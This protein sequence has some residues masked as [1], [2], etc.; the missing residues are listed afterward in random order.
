MLQSP[1]YFLWEGLFLSRTQDVFQANRM[2][3]VYEKAQRHKRLLLP[4]N[5]NFSKS[6]TTLRSQ[7]HVCRLSCVLDGS[8]TYSTNRLQTVVSWWCHTENPRPSL[9]GVYQQCVLTAQVNVLLISVGVSRNVYLEASKMGWWDREEKEQRKEN[10]SG[11]LN[12]N[13]LKGK[14]LY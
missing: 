12:K 10:Q 14:G 9:E 8:G 1:S 3:R 2:N 6:P 4:K 7:P 5:K 13:E 11:I